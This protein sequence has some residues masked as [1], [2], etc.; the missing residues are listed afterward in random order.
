MGAGAGGRG[1]SDRGGRQQDMRERRSG[2]RRLFSLCEVCFKKMLTGWGEE[3][4]RRGEERRAQ[5]IVVGI[6]SLICV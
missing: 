5:H 6:M 4:K 1:C 3:E 2:T